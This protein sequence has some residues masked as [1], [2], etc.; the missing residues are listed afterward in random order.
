MGNDIS[1]GI[2]LFNITFISETATR[3]LAMKVDS[4]SMVEARSSA[5]SYAD[6]QAFLKNDASFP[7]DTSSCAYCLAAHSILVDIMMG[8]MNPFAIAYQNCIQDLQ[9]HLFL[10]L[11]LHY[12]DEG[13]A[14][15]HMGLRI[16]YWLMQ[17]F[18]YFLSQQKF[19]RDPL[20][21]DFDGLM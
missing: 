9:S 17:Q 20:L 16:L 14:C 10:G 5:M 6:T 3:A 21:P 19:G 2:T 7:P 8:P 18:L 11:W 13:G 1:D 4:L 12:G 15:Y